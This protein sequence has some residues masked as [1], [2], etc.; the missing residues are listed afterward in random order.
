MTKPPCIFCN[1]TADIFTV[2]IPAFGDDENELVPR[3]VCGSCW[4]VIASIAN[5]ALDQRVSNLEKRIA[6]GFFDFPPHPCPERL[7]RAEPAD[8]RRIW[9]EMWPGKF[10]LDKR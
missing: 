5:A 6:A 3:S 2:E 10:P 1:H 7:R 4:E 9:A 8:I